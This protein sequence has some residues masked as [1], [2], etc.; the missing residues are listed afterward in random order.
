M[1]FINNYFLFFIWRF[2]NNRHFIFSIIFESKQQQ[3]KL[4]AHEILHILARGLFELTKRPNQAAPTSPDS[5]SPLAICQRRFAQLS[6]PTVIARERNRK[7]GGAL[8]PARVDLKR[9]FAFFAGTLLV[10]VHYGQHLL[11]VHL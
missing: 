3:Q 10:I 11:V 8:L 9:L 4:E 5:L 1:L 6:W 2:R 7:N